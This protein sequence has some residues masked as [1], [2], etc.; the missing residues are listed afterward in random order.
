MQFCRNHIYVLLPLQLSVL[1]TYAVH[2]VKSLTNKLVTNAET[3][4]HN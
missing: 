2:N 3:F 4:L 1:E